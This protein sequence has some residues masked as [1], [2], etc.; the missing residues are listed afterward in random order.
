MRMGAKHF[1]KAHHFQMGVFI[2]ICY[3][4]SYGSFI[5]TPRPFSKV[6][7]KQDYASPATEDITSLYGFFFFFKKQK[8]DP[9][10]FPLEDTG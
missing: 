6:P 2:L 5:T 7:A 8:Q 3:F 4:S 10:S 9:A 1:S